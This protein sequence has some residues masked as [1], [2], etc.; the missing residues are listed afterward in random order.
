M[1]YRANIYVMRVARF[2]L[3][4]ACALFL[5]SLFGGV[6][7]AVA[8]F[9]LLFF[10]GVPAAG[11]Y[12]QAHNRNHEYEDLLNESFTGKPKGGLTFGLRNVRH[13]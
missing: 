2:I 6:Q 4:A 12:T 5:I 8:G 11:A 10:V 3:L 1:G 7:S 9:L 13:D